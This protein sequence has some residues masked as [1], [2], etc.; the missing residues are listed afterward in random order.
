MFFW[1][2]TRGSQDAYHTQAMG[3]GPEEAVEMYGQTEEELPPYPGAKKILHW[4]SRM[5]GAAAHSSYKA[6]D[7]TVRLVCFIA[8]YQ[9]A[10]LYCPCCCQA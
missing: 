1:Q 4:Q 7:C 2:L 8:C 3:I 9:V 6:V 10:F 5:V